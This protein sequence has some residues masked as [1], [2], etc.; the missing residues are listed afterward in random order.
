MS[1][2]EH[3]GI[4]KLATLAT[5]P[6]N[7]A[8]VNA[9]AQ[10]KSEE[11]FTEDKRF[12]QMLESMRPLLQSLILPFLTFAGLVLIWVMVQQHLATDLPTPAQVWQQSLELFADP[13]Y[14]AGPNDMGIGWQVL[15]SLGRVML[16]FGLAVLVG[17]PVGF[18][19]GMSPVCKRAWLPLVQILRPVSPL[20]WLPIG[21]LLFKAVDPSA[22]FVIF[23]TAIWPVIVNT[24]AGVEAIPNDYMNVAR[25]LRLGRLEIARRIL[26]PATLPA[27]ITG[28]KLS[29]GV[30]W[31]V[32][33][34][35]EMLTGGIGIGFYI[36][37]E[38]NNL[39]VSS[40]IV[41]ILIIGVVGILLESLMSALERRFNYNSH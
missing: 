28:M 41:A 34:A 4:A 3:S 29:L 18:L 6:T 36:W 12:E 8:P 22:I 37:D 17:I 24:A 39:N 15:Y 30:A 21:L 20:A 5:T 25:V 27:I 16:G 40:I 26:I 13:F 7:K 31:M 38:W 19:M 9:A 1:T 10:A 14:Q 2:L 32:I 11:R 35:A 33:V 23:I